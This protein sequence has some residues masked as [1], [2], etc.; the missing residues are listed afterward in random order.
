RVS[1]SAATERRTPAAFLAKLPANPRASANSPVVFSTVVF[2][3]GNSYGPLLG[4]YTV[5]Y[6]GVYQ[7]SFQ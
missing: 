6:A 2:N 5:P 4:V 3:I 1:S 7:F